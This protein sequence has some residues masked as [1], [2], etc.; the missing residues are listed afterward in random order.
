[1][2]IISN[3]DDGLFAL[4]A[5]YLEVEFDYIITAE[6][7]GYYKPSLGTLNW[8]WRGWAWL[9]SEYYTSRRACSTIT[10]RARN[11]AWTPPGSI[12]GQPRE[13]SGRPPPA[14]ADFD[15]EVPHLESLVF[16]LGR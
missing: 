8:P 4:T 13:A 3:V 7:A 6:Q 10:F 15:I 14:E 2:A 16:A 9:P 5:R 1:M 11:W 12:G